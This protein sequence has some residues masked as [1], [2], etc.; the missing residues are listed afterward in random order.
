[1][2][3]QSVPIGHIELDQKLSASCRESAEF[4]EGK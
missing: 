1:M 4:D 3:L 2:H